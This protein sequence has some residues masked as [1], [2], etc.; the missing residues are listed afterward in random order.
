VD[1]ELSPQQ[2][3]KR[4]RTAL[5]GPYGHPFHPVL[6]TIPIGAWTASIIFDV[7]ALFADDR[8]AF[9]RG[10]LW[11]VG[12]GVIGALMAAVFGVMDFL[13]LTSGTKARR[14]AVVHMTLNLTVIALFIV[15]FVIRAN[16]GYDVLSIP[17][18]VVS[19]IAYAL[20]T[21]SGYIGGILAYHYG[22]RVADE[23]TQAEGFR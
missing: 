9:V 3:A 4:P 2:R 15:S 21:V 10:S 19:L 13:T 11:L 6:V 12:I 20:V 7:V 17:A 8:E 23:A 16:S 18:F 22:V 1:N 5:A 14:T